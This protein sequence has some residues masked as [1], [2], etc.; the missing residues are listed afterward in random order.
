M[1]GDGEGG[2]LMGELLT[3]RGGPHRA[4]R[5]VGKMLDLA[6]ADLRDIPRP[7]SPSI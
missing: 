3:L 1:S 2:I 4:R 7:S 5:R 6:R